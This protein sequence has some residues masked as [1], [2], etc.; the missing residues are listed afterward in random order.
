[1]L[2]GQKNSTFLKTKEQRHEVELRKKLFDVA[3]NFDVAMLV[4]YSADS[5]HARP[6]VI[7][8]LD[9]GIGVYLITNT[10]SF[11][12]MKSTSIKMRCSHFKVP[13]GP[14]Q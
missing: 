1:V 12:S 13:E 10:T 14:L 11:K 4:T 3:E 8:E 5:I 6:M 9:F 7:A 2:D